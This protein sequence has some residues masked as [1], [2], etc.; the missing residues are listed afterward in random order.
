MGIP[1]SRLRV[2]R[3]GLTRRR[4]GAKGCFSVG[5][6]PR[7]AVEAPY[8]DRLLTEAREILAELPHADLAVQWDVAVE[9]AVLEGLR[10]VHFQPAYEGI[11]ERLAALG[12]MIPP[13]V[14]MGFHLCYGDSG[15]KHFKEPADTSLLEAVEMLLAEGFR[16][17]RTVHLAFGHDEEVG[18]IRGAREIAALLRQR[19]VRLEMVL[20]EGGVIADGLL[21]GVSGPV[22]LIGIA[23]KGFVS[24][25]LSTRSE[26]GHSSLPPP[27]SAVGIL[28]AAI[29]RLEDNPMPARL[30]RPTR[31]LF[32][33]IGRE[34]SSC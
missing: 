3:R 33:R 26:G 15:G 1:T 29:A 28:S 9:F 4:E 14:E 34:L 18:G 24:I 30:E 8:R 6:S 16:P 13:A 32:D 25:E 27:Q 17:R 10:R 20:D 5:P 12:A 21:P 23:E 2:S 11:I 7:R 19:G 31:E 22:A